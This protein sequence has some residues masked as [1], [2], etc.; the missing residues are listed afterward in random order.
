MFG[1][2]VCDSTSAESIEMI[3][4]H[5]FCRDFTQ[6]FRDEAAWQLRLYSAAGNESGERSGV[7]PPVSR[8]CT[9][10]LTHAARQFSQP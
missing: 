8:F 3:K 9:G 5:A 6:A 4:R 1:T 2:E 7:S 10:K